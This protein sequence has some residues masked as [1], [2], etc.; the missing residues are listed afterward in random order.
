VI[1]PEVR[2]SMRQVLRDI[3]SGEFARE[4]I[5]ENR[6]G[7]ENFQ[8]MRSEQQGHQVEQVG[9]DLRSMMPWIADDS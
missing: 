6:A 3:Q 8:R 2:E 9:K 5:A 4:W 7:Q 1:G